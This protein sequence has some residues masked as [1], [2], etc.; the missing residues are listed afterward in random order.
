VG[1][2]L[3]GVRIFSRFLDT[4]A[5]DY[6]DF[7]SNSGGEWLFDFLSFSADSFRSDEV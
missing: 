6:F 7:M 2:F 3:L 5:E 4:G 1:H